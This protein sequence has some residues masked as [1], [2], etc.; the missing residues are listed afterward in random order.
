MKLTEIIMV[1]GSPA[2]TKIHDVTQWSLYKS[3][4]PKKHGRVSSRR[5]DECCK[6]ILVEWLIEDD[7]SPFLFV[8]KGSSNSYTIK[9]KGELE[10][11]AKSN[12]VTLHL[13]LCT[14]T[15]YDSCT[16]RIYGGKCRKREGKYNNRCGCS[17]V[18]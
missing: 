6:G 7:D 8:V 17:I 3:I 1:P 18:V 13:L 10:R 11:V 9:K 14:C 4:P 5:A 2:R 12:R 15:I 16:K